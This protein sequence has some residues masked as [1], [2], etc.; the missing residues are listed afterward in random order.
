M[1]VSYV[2]SVSESVSPS[3]SIRYRT[4][5]RRFVTRL[6]PDKRTQLIFG[7]GRGN[8]SEDIVYLDSQQV[9]NSEYGTQLAGGYVIPYQFSYELEKT[10][11]YYGPM[12]QVSRVITTP[13]AG[14]L[15]W[16]KVNDTGTSAKA[17]PKS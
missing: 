12:L 17:N 8:A 9:A 2:A 14:T 7:S 13:Q 16:P 4:V 10:M 3:Y 1:V 11:A 6:S 15:Y 5:P